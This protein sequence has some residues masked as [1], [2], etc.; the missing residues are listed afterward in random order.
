MQIFAMAL[1]VLCCVGKCLN[2]Y[3]DFCPY[4]TYVPL[5]PLII[6]LETKYGLGSHIQDVSPKDLT[7]FL[8]V[9]LPIP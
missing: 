9:F 4:L 8:K 1:F 2:I 5:S 6:R 3:D 7:T